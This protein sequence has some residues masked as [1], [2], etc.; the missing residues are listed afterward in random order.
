MLILLVWPWYEGQG[1]TTIGALYPNTKEWFAPQ[2]LSRVMLTF[3]TT[4]SYPTWNFHSGTCGDNLGSPLRYNGRNLFL[5][6][7]RWEHPVIKSSSNA[8]KILLVWDDFMCVYQTDVQIN[9]CD[10]FSWIKV[11]P[12]LNPKGESE[13]F[14]LEKEEKMELYM[15]IILSEPA[16]K[17]LSIAL[18]LPAKLWLVSCHLRCTQC[19]PICNAMI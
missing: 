6:R 10:L 2:N 13:Y 5:V 12:K 15:F 7:W 18:A 4:H 8:T 3:V 9:L 17:P 11:I 19:W 14:I 16:F 1:Q